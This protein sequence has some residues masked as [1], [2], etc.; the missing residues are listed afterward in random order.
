MSATITRNTV[1]V[2]LDDSEGTRAAIG[3]AAAAADAHGC[4]LTFLHAYPDF[5][6]SAVRGLTL[7]ES[8]LEAKSA[9]I[10][11]RAEAQLRSTG[12]DGVIARVTHCGPPAE[13]LSS[14]QA[15]VRMVVMGRRGT[16]GFRDLLVGSTAYGVAE[17]SQVPV[18][19]VPSEW[20]AGCAR[21]RPV[22]LGLDYDTGN[23]AIGFAFD[24]AT[25]TSQRIQATHV[26]TPQIV[27]VQAGI[28]YWPPTASWPHGTDES[29]DEVQRAVAEQLAGWSE[30]YPD[31]KVKRD[32][33]AGSPAGELVAEGRGA[34]LLVVG[35]KDHGTLSSALLGSVARNLMHHATCPLAVV[36]TRG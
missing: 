3:W 5:V 31:V 20:D 12:W 30:K 9:R 16:G 35:G 22:V 36:H 18:V 24:L 2:G 27:P 21:D 7:P 13:F 26:F 29:L 32:V 14:Y 23:A 17:S 10:M 4:S 1:V 25:L 11:D 8:E 28:G 19:I 33:V 6:H 34:S 15:E